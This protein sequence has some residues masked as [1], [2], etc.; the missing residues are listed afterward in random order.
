MKK[1][2]WAIDKC[3][4]N[5]SFFASV[6]LGLSIV[7]SFLFF[8]FVQLE[9][10]GFGVSPPYVKN[11]ELTRGS[12][13]E[14][15]IFLVRSQP[16]VEMKAT[17]DVDVPGAEEW[18]TV[19][20]GTE[21]TLPEGEKKVPIVVR[22][23]IPEK[24]EYG[25]YEGKVRVRTGP[26]DEDDRAS[27]SVTIALG[28]Q[29]NVDLDVSDKVIRDFDI[30]KVRIRDF[31]E[32]RTVRWLDYPGKMH[33]VMDLKNTGNISIAPDKVRVDIYDVKGEEF[34]ERTEHTNK[35]KEIE[36]FKTGEVIAEL[37]SHL[38]PGSYQGHYSIY[39]GEDVVR[40]G[41]LS[42]GIKDVGTIE[43]DEGYGF[44]GLS[45]WHKTT[46]VGP[47][48]LLFLII[49]AFVFYF[50]RRARVF[51]L[52][53]PSRCKRAVATIS[54]KIKRPRLRRKGVE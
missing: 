15:R 53:V 45:L 21:V 19:Q 6:S 22:V 13:Y 18:I 8:P 42:F 9:A 17:I 27:G 50:S 2:F 20:P 5:T 4:F 37:P 23:E 46:I 48:V 35:I 34:L 51:V 32:G 38:P 26:A 39:N 10:S 33:L 41:A 29:I 3:L 52:S 49:L 30:T 54:K 25:S 16:D 47:F 12:V 44:Q 40:S 1:E 43:G 36:P 24:A 11:S 14:Q 28:A 7:I 31:N